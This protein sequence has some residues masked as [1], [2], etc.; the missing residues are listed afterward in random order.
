MNPDHIISL[1]EIAENILREQPTVLSVRAPVKIFGDIH[2]QYADLMTFFELYGAPHLN[3]KKKDIENFDYIFIGDFVDRGSHSLETIMLLLALKATYPNQIHMI[4]GNHEDIAINTDFG[5]M[6]ECAER[7]QE[8]VQDPDSVFQRINRLFQWLPLAAVVE[9][10]ILCIHGG[11]GAN[12]KTIDD[13]RQIQRP[14]E[15][16]QEVTTREHK[17]IL[18]I[19]W[20]DPT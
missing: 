5:F 18:D 4:R 12:V 2:G 20:S 15:V 19:L 8:D 9:E 3:G 6:E 17:L 14:I 10:K 11:I 13:I 7:C 1:V 16:V